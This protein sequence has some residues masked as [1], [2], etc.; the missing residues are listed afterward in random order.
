MHVAILHAA[1]AAAAAAVDSALPIKI[2]VTN[3]TN[4]TNAKKIITICFSRYKLA[5]TCMLQFFILQ[6][7]QQQPQEQQL[8]ILPPIKIV[9]TNVR[10]PKK[11]LQY[12]S[13]DISLL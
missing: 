5:I 10:M 6:L 1:V 2:L 11:L 12:V 13:M 9:V 8:R 3:A 7:Q 4:V